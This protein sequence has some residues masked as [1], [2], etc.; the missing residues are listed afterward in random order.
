[1]KAATAATAVVCRTEAGGEVGRFGALEEAATGTDETM[2]REPVVVAR[3]CAI[4]G[5]GNEALAVVTAPVVGEVVA[6][7]VGERVVDGDARAGLGVDASHVVAEGGAVGIAVGSTAR[8]STGRVKRSRSRSRS[9]SRCR[10]KSRSRSRSSSII[11]VIII[12]GKEKIGVD[13]LVE[14]SIDEV[15][16]WTEAQQRLTEADHAAAGARLEVA[17]AGTAG[18]SSAPLHRGGAQSVVEEASR[19]GHEQLVNV[20]MRIE[21]FQIYRHA[22]HTHCTLE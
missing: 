19:K 18:Q 17:D 14:K 7:L 20:R 22:V 5:A 21:Q 13:H 12:I 10:S 9:R 11:I 6:H 2:L 3:G 4:G 8:A 1:V 16:A 15:R